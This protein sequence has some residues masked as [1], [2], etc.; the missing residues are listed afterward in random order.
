MSTGKKEK[1]V[2]VPDDPVAGF[3]MAVAVLYTQLGIEKFSNV[4]HY[5]ELLEQACDRHIYEVE[6]DITPEKKAE[7][8]KREFITVFRARYLQFTDLEYES[9][10]TGVDARM[11]LQTC[12]K[13]HEKDLDVNDFLG[14]LFERFFNENPKFLPPSIKQICGAF[15]WNKFLFENKAVVKEK[16][17]KELANKESLALIAR[18]R[19]LMRVSDEFDNKECKEKVKKVLR[20]FIDGSIILKE[21]RGAME[22]IETEQATWEKP[23]TK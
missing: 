22:A 11:M 21:F 9:I 4:K 23:E 18:S 8:S 17:R 5:V 20:E 14:W 7:K 15:V 12:K 16:H 6:H 1:R 13:L 3:A 19:V 2:P 10:I